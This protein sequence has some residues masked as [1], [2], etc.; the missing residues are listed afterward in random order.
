MYLVIVDS[1]EAVTGVE[2]VKWLKRF[3]CTVMEK[4]LEIGD[5]LVSHDVVIERKKVMDFINSI[6]DGRLF[7]QAIN[8][9]KNFK[10]PIIIIEG[11]LW[12]AAS[13][14]NIHH[15][16]II[17]ALTSL[18]DADVN[19][20]FTSSEESTAYT[21]YSLAKLEK[22]KGKNNVKLSM[23]RKSLS[24]KELQIRFL[25]SLPGIGSKRAEKILTIFET[26]LQ[27]LSSVNLWSRKIDNISESTVALIKKILFTKFTEKESEEQK[28]SIDELL[29]STDEQEVDSK[30][31]GVKRGGIYDYL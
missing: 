3:G 16:A 13:R 7:N 5:Y 17:G 21:I 27:A 19:V 22:E 23:V 31:R 14:R 10:K 1:K 29:K 9:K 28:L 2:V 25:S 30:S 20:V 24:I 8:L 15:H 11:N 26:P 6:I 18:I 4:K 12:K